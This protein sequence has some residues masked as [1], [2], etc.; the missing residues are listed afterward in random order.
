MKNEKWW[1][2]IGSAIKPEANEDIEEFAKRI[3][4]IAWKKSRQYD[5]FV[6]IDNIRKVELW[7]IS[8]AA[9]PRYWT[10]A[11][12]LEEELKELNK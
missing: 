3:T 8:K 9:I 6:K 2:E 12:L 1:N 4:M 5:E 11:S 7:E 10:Y